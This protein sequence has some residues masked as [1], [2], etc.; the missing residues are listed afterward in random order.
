[1]L[2]YVIDAMLVLCNEVLLKR[3]SSRPTKSGLNSK[4]ILD[5]ETQSHWNQLLWTEYCGSL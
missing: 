3:P 1:M 2:Y 5:S 4:I